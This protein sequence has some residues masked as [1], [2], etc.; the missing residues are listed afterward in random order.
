ME[1]SENDG[2]GLISGIEKSAKIEAEQALKEAEKQ[3]K[4]RLKYA[5][6]KV[7]SILKEAEEN[8]RV[9]C[10]AAR[11]H[12]L[13]G[14]E[15]ELKRA[16]MQIREKILG[17]T[18]LRVK[19]ELRRMLNDSR[20]RTVLLNWI[21]EAMIG[22]GVEKAEVNAS[23]KERDMIDKDLLKRSEKK[24]E[25]LTGVSVSLVLSEKPVLGSQGV[26]LTSEDGRTAFNNQVEVRLLRKQ[27]M[28][29]DIIY[30]RLL[31]K[32]DQVM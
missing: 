28:I 24:V 3:A 9:Q 29:R 31:N 32:R 2:K 23:K 14:V 11:R 4:E 19:E 27:G 17:E 1:S 5:D 18:L 25:A 30:E 21:V 7:E 26:M 12:I 13:A 10:E 6:K 22:L 8:S 20:Y 15:I 16:D